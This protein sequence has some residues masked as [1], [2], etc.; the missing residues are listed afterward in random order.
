MNTPQLGIKKNLKKILLVEDNPGDIR[1]TQ[2]VL[3]ETKLDVDLFVVSDSEDVMD[4]LLGQGSYSE[5]VIPD[6]ILLD[7]NMP[8]KTGHEVLIEIKSNENLKRIPVIIL[9]TSNATYDVKKAY[10][11]NANAYMVKPLDFDDY[12]NSFQSLYDFWLKTA[13]INNN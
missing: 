8:K 13:I 3:E 9:S 1:L 2:E 10:N 6:I 11:S 7:L 12:L 4:F 5:S